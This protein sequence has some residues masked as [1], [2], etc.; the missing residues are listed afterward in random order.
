MLKRL[1]RV[2]WWVGALL[3]VSAGL[4]LARSG[5]LA[6]R[7]AAAPGL[8]AEYDT[9]RTKEAALV[10]RC[11]PPPKRGEGPSNAQLLAALDPDRAMQGAPMSEQRAYA[12][13]KAQD[14]A[15]LEQLSGL[16]RKDSE[17]T[18][19]LLLAVFPGLAWLGAWSVSYVLGGRFWLPP[20]T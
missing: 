18:K 4:M 1:G 10:M 19:L 11:F 16:H 9:L 17:A 12:Q 13:L 6:A 5:Q 20:K 15:V 14:D 2:I 7:M 3:F 8:R